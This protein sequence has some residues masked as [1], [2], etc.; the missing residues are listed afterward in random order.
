MGRPPHV[1]AEAVERARNVVKT[2]TD[3][4][5]LRV[6]QATL[7]P[8]LGLTLDQTA[9]VLGRDRYWI[10]RA[11]NGFLKGKPLQPH[12]GR[13]R[14]LVPVDDEFEL[15]K[16]AIIQHGTSLALRKSI[17]QALRDQLNQRVPEPVSD[18]AISAML[19]RVAPRIIPGAKGRDLSDMEHHL[20]MIW[21][22]EAA[23]ARQQS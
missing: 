3:A 23:L 12:G 13:R 5:E 18:S 20:A 17:R 21:R 15:V 8:L 6:A 11:R 9:H 19:D 2:T 7:L 10:S 4:Q 16:Q 1:T 22:R 14:E